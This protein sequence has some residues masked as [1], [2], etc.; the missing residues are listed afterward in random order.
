LL[1]AV[2]VSLLVG[3][4]QLDLR[5]STP[6][7]RAIAQET[8]ESNELLVIFRPGEYASIRNRWAVYV[9]GQPRAWVP[10]D[11]DRVESIA[12]TP[13]SHRVDI[14]HHQRYMPVLLVP[15]PPLTEV[16]KASRTTTC[17]QAGRCGV[18]VALV[19]W[20]HAMRMR[21]DDAHASQLEAAASEAVKTPREKGN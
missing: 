4:S 15:L 17:Q 20:E 9:D 16:E 6:L 8:A 2:A 19:R 7:L 1:V 10:T 18:V 3:C 5:P 11:S 13:G 14:E 12:V 21:V